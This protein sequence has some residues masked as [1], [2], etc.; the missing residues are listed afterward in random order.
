[1]V[2]LIQETSVNL[3]NKLSVPTILLSISWQYSL[4]YHYSHQTLGWSFEP[5]NS[6]SIFTESLYIYI[7]DIIN[8]KLWM[9]LYTMGGLNRD[10]ERV[11]IRMGAMI[12]EVIINLIMGFVKLSELNSNFL[13][14]VQ[15]NNIKLRPPSPA[16]AVWWINRCERVTYFIL[17]FHILNLTPTLSQF[18]VHTTNYT[19]LSLWNIQFSLSDC[20]YL[21]TR[22]SET[23]Q[24]VLNT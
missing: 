23:R 1:M 21:A 22:Y 20:V 2:R 4:I 5:E 24:S 16:V 7:S 13:C 6:F 10:Y 8:S 3:E 15:H 18:T 17:L 19:T 14:T 12:I 9:F 11:W